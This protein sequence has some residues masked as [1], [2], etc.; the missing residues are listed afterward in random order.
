MQEAGEG[1]SAA[2]AREG[3][4]RASLESPSLLA[5]G[6]P[7]GGLEASAQSAVALPGRNWEGAP[8]GTGRR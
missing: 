7:A 8:V 2:V 4:T 3:D 5:D 1:D 6:T